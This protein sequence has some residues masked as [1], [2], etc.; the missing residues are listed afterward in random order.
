MGQL[1][2]ATVRGAVSRGRGRDARQAWHPSRGVGNLVGGG[3]FLSG[4]NGGVALPPRTQRGQV[5]E[6]HGW[7]RLERGRG[8][9]RDRAV[10]W[11]SPKGGRWAQ[12]GLGAGG[13]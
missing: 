2:V 5:R 7:S 10:L 4:G 9:K 12:V 3:Y 8:Q 11:G 6:G 1:A 13:C